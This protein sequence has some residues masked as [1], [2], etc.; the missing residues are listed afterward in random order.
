MNSDT[1]YSIRPAHTYDCELFHELRNDPN[2]RRYFQQQ[3]DI[4]FE[5]HN[6]WFYKKLESD[7]AR[8]FTIITFNGVAV[9]YIRF[10]KMDRGDWSI[11]VAIK[12]NL[13]WRGIMSRMI[14]A[15]LQNMPE[16]TIIARVHR[17]NTASIR[18]FES[19]RFAPTGTEGEF[20]VFMRKS[21]EREK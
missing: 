2:Y 7:D 5:E 16:C 15:A 1:L 9:G 21:R 6:L 10:D 13:R 17:D 3:K 20:M 18:L 12:P 8:Y 14:L 19:V 4:P 11:S